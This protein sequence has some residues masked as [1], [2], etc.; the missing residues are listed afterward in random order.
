MSTPRDSEI[1]TRRTCERTRDGHDGHV[2][3]QAAP[4]PQGQAPTPIEIY[5]MIAE[6]AYYR[7]QKRGFAPGLEEQDWREAEAE[8]MERLR[9]Q[10]FTWKGNGSPP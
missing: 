4:S 6:A 3:E 10:G 9:A 7:A 1:A 5:E 8:V 2:Q